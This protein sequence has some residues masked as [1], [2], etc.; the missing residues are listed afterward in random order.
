MY[1]EAHSLKGEIRNLIDAFQKFEEAS[2][3]GHTEVTKELA[4]CYLHG[5]ECEKDVIKA[6]E[7]G[8]SK[9]KRKGGRESE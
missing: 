1:Q 7:F 6:E 8:D 3:S 4:W 9:S 2:G 5:R